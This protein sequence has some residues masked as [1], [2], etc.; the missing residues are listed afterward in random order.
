MSQLFLLSIEHS[1]MKVIAQ[2]FRIKCM[3]NNGSM[4]ANCNF[5]ITEP[6]NTF[7]YIVNIFASYSHYYIIFNSVFLLLIDFFTYESYR[8]VYKQS[9]SGIYLSIVNTRHSVFTK[10]FFLK[11]TTSINSSNFTKL[12]IFHTI[13]AKFCNHFIDFIHLV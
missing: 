2:I 9:V 3:M 10:V 7:A 13:R 12:F 4:T 5:T 1:C 6:S 11:V 8:F